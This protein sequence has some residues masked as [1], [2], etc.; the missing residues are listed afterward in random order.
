MC[1]RYG[2]YAPVVGSVCSLQWKMSWA[3]WL[4]IELFINV[5]KSESRTTCANRIVPVWRTDCRLQD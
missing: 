5:V 4:I 2:F 1:S 3:D